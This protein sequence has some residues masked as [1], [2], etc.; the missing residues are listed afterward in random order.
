L[1]VATTAPM[2]HATVRYSI[3][4]D[5]NLLP[6]NIYVQALVD[7]GGSGTYRYTNGLRLTIGGTLP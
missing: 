5:S 1:P 4:N 7:I 3:P 6:A 2:G